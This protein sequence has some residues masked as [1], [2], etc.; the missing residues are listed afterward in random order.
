MFFTLLLQDFR[1]TLLYGRDVLSS[2]DVKNALVQRDLIEKQLT[3]KQNSTNDGLF[4]RGRTND[5]SLGGRSKVGPNL[6]PQIR[7]RHV[8][9]AN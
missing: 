5:S 2:G 4:V 8:I 1:E 3:Q 9:F 7:P 6:E